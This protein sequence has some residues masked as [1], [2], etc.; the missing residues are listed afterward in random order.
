MDWVTLLELSPSNKSMNAP[1]KFRMVVPSYARKRGVR[2]RWLQTAH[3]GWGQ[4]VWML[5][6]VEIKR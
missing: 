1:K 2:V 4:H 6:G 5:N 3:A